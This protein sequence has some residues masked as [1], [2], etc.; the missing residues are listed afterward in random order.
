ML[1][2]RQDLIALREGCMAAAQLQKRRILVCAG[3]G[4]VSSGSLKI[5]DR[6]K[7][8]IEANGISCPVELKVEPHE[9]GIHGGECACHAQAENADNSIAMKK[10]GCHGFCEMGPLVR[11]EPEGYLYTKVQL[12]D[13]EEIVEK[14]ILNNEPIDRLAYKRNGEIYR[15]QEEIPFYK[16]QTRIVLEHCGHIE[17]RKSTRLNS[18]HP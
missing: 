7:E 5:F 11:I 18:S 6:L 14:T 17:D 15:K 12:S 2:N 10:S 3:T 16:N 8:L 1:K 13:C 9:P 4:C